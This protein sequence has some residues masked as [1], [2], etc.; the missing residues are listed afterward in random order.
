MGEVVVVLL[1]RMGAGALVDLAR[2][3]PRGVPVHPDSSRAWSREVDEPG[4]DPDGSVL[5]VLEVEAEAL[6]VLAQ[7]VRVVG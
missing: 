2:E 3:L 6:Q 1:R 7:A 4:S 5:E